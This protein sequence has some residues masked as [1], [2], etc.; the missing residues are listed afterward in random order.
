MKIRGFY[1]EENRRFSPSQSVVVCDHCK[2]QGHVKEKCYRIIGFPPNF[3]NYK[4]KRSST[5]A[6]RE[7]G[8]VGSTSSVSGSSSLSQDQINQL[9]SLLDNMKIK[10]NGSNSFVNFAGIT[11]ILK[12]Y[13]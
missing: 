6:V 5:N 4:G 2:K 12:H 9:M 1:Q 3:K 8:D 7:E 11:Y 13:L 10:E